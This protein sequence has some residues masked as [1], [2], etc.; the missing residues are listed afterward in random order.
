MVLV[1]RGRANSSLR[2]RESER[3]HAR[4]TV[5]YLSDTHTRDTHT[6]GRDSKGWGLLA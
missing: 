6:P 1:E 4:E 5:R 3:L 2:E